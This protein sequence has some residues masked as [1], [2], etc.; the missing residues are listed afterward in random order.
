MKKKFKQILSALLVAVMLI[1]IAPVGD[2]SFKA[3]AYVAYSN[4]SMLKHFEESQGIS[5]DSIVEY[6]YDDFDNDSK[7]EMF[8]LVGYDEDNIALAELYFVNGTETELINEYEY[9]TKVEYKYLNVYTICSKKFIMLDREYGNSYI[10]DIYTV[11]NGSSVKTN[12]TNLDYGIKRKFDE[13]TLSVS[14]T[15][16]DGSTDLN[17]NMT[18][19]TEKEY[20]FYWDETESL[21][22]E[23]GGITVTRE[24]V[25]KVSGM[26]AFFQKMD[27]LNYKIQNIFYRENGIL[28]INCKIKREDGY[29]NENINL[30]YN[31][32]TKSFELLNVYDWKTAELLKAS[33]GGIYDK[34]IT[35][36]VTYPKRFLSVKEWYMISKGNN[37]KLYQEVL[38]QY[39]GLWK[40]YQKDN[41]EKF[42]YS[43]NEYGYCNEFACYTVYDAMGYSKDYKIYYSFC[44]LDDNGIDELIVCSHSDDLNKVY[45]NE[46]GS[47]INAIYTYSN[48]KVYLLA[49]ASYRSQMRIHKSGIISIAGSG[50]AYLNGWGFYYISTGGKS[51]DKLCYV[52]HFID[53]ED[54]YREYY[55]NLTNRGSNDYEDGEIISYE[56][57]NGFFEKYTGKG[58]NDY[59]K[60][61]VMDL[62]WL[63]VDNIDPIFHENSYI[64]DIWL[65]RNMEKTPESKLID[66]IFDLDS[67][68]TVIYDDLKNNRDFQ[69]SVNMWTGMKVIFDPEKG[70]E[71]IY[72]SEE[73]LYE[74]LIFDLVKKIM[75]GKNED[76][77]NV[78]IDA[79]NTASGTVGKVTKYKGYID[80]I[81]TITTEPEK[82]L[83]E[84]LKD[85]K[86]NPKS[87]S[88]SKFYGMLNDAD[89]A[90]SKWTDN[91][92]I[93][94]IG[95][96]AD[97]SSDVAEFYKRLACYIM[98]EDMSEETVN[99]LETL[100]EQTS[101]E[102]F[103]NA[104]EKVIVAYNNYNIVSIICTMKLT[105]DT[106]LDIGGAA[107]DDLAKCSRVYS[108]LRAGYKVGV[109]LCDITM[110][111]SKTIDAYK[112]CGATKEFINANKTAI[113]VLKNKYLTSRNDFDAGVYVNA[114]RAYQ[115]AFEIDMENGIEFV[116]KANDEGLVNKA[117]KLTVHAFNFFLNKDN[118]TSY[119]SMAES[120]KSILNTMEM[121]FFTLNNTWKFN[122]DY[123]CSDYP[124]IFP[125]YVNKEISQSKYAPNITSAY[126]DKSGKT[127]LTWNRPLIFKDKDGN[128]Q[129][130]WGSL[131]FDGI[132]ATETVGGSKNTYDN[133]NINEAPSTIEFYNA[134]KFKTFNKDYTL[135]AYTDTTDGKVYS[136]AKKISVGNPLLKAEI[137][138]ASAS[139]A[140]S[141]QVMFSII[142]DTS[143]RYDSL[144]YTI[145]R[146]S[147]GGSWTKI[148]DIARETARFNGKLTLYK[149]TTAKKG[150][151]YSYKV[152]SHMT[153]DNGMT[154]NSP[155]SSVVSVIGGVGMKKLDINVRDRL[156]QI[157]TRSTNEE[158][159]GI[160]LSWTRTANVDGYEIYRIASY[161]TVYQLI[162]TVGK[163]AA[164]YVDYDVD[165]CTTYK[166]IVCPYYNNEEKVYDLAALEQ[167]TADYKVAKIYSVDVSDITM[168][169]KKSTTITPSITADDGAKYTVTYSSSNA[170]VATVDQNGKVYAAKKGSATITCTV[171]DS[172]GNTVQDTCKVTVKYSFG[173]WLIK[174]LLFGWIWY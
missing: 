39:T 95:T 93:E 148:D 146:K 169:Y 11:T 36:N 66:S 65:S 13:S 41:K 74:T 45:G 136:A 97:I 122:S 155:E 161:G 25:S 103:K 131:T 156:P 80:K 99:L 52:Q 8:V 43:R 145:Y 128:V 105:Q 89:Q 134:S 150:Q 115:Y 5:E 120:Q 165:A 24:Q 125:V 132:Y 12:I 7:Y 42:W 166:Y 57:F 174:I 1:G 6:Q 34:S 94:G 162:K 157:R 170:K 152:V 85:W 139:E 79:A 53:F 129:T 110:N 81:A 69:D 101:N 84:I 138:V 59:L 51:I 147:D 48:G 140:G 58:Y 64:A 77:G 33:F 83:L 56:E 49:E 76:T 70:L 19:R 61:E 168:N 86:F 88:Y 149:D 98:L 4:N 126:I 154:L 111:T 104:L 119:E 108:T 142:D 141:A 16:F 91:K 20:Y 171:T 72:L 172:N 127:L 55:Y 117:R 90:S 118:K 153:F 135:A 107:F 167:G 87:D 124:D 31:Y 116:K 2:I 137:R 37:Q 163:D 22:I 158:K 54:N 160:E 63:Q 82:N 121:N 159:K 112:I 133:A 47:V 123:L 60:S 68:S 18:V 44:D 40:L 50:G 67:L 144:K 62:D 71:D 106:A 38:N 109:A 28:N 130:L 15:C 151:K 30:K 100:K 3:S 14:K 96:I 73:D 46:N 10:T 21:F 102:K 75:Y 113:N 9:Y 92:F 114:I 32:Q 27:D 164:S 26:P 23:Y 29:D 143:S 35:A 78:I 173:Q 17:G